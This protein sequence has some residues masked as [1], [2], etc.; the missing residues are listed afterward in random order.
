LLSKNVQKILTRQ[1]KNATIGG[2]K[3]MNKLTLVNVAVTEL[4]IMHAIVTFQRV[5]LQGLSPETKRWYKCRLF[6]IAQGLGETK[7]MSEIFDIDL[8][9]LREKWENK[10]TL[11]PDTLHGYI[12]VL[13]RLFKWLFEKGLISENLTQ[14]LPLPR[15]PKRGRRGISDENAMLILEAAK[16]WSAR[17]YAML[18]VF[19]STSCRRGG[20]ADM[21][22]TDIHVNEPE[23]RC[24]QIEVVEKGRKER[25]VIMDSKT[26]KALRA[27]L[28]VRPGKSEYVFVTDE[29]GKLKADSV[30]EIIDRYKNRLG[31]QGPCSPH[32]WRH[33]W[34]RT[35]LSNKMPI[36][37]AAQLGGHGSTTVTFQYYGQFAMNELQEAYDRYYEPK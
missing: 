10:K 5:A 18:L 37:Q 20:V 12:R 27:W 33:R 17:D 2:N 1:F 8:I 23:P 25:T 19:A 16:K 22:M 6:L 7:R 21:K 15:L 32:Q 4:T 29:G 14:N 9:R 11:S 30:S 26:L 35:L 34:F 36:A 31:L 24:R 13:R 28:K 3:N